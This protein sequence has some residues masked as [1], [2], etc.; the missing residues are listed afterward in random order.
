MDFIISPE[1]H[2]KELADKLQDIVNKTPQDQLANSLEL[3]LA[4]QDLQEFCHKFGVGLH[5]GITK[6]EKIKLVLYPLEK[7]LKETATEAGKFSKSLGIKL[8]EN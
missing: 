3:R 4:A 7:E 8:S 6:G 5:I 2:M 1:K